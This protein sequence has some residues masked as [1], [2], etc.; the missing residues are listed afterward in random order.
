MKIYIDSAKLDDIKKSIEIYPISGVT[1]NPSNIIKV[2]P[3]DL[4]RHIHQ[5][6]KLNN[7]GEL[8]IQVV[9]EDY[10]GMLLDAQKIVKEFGKET[11]IKVPVTENG[12]KAIKELKR[13]EY[14]ITATNIFTKM[15]A[16]LVLAFNV[17]YIAV[18]VNRISSLG[19]DP[20]EVIKFIRNQIDE[21]NYHTQIIGAS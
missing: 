2:E 14:H 6:K 18:Y 7:N 16:Y 3:K 1:T 19:N 21:G 10:E 12:L 17:D 13:Q 5:I 8:H 20:F 9:S 4:I 15:Q 11:Y